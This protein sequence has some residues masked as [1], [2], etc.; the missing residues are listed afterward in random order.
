[1]QR[2]CKLCVKYT[3][4]KRTVRARSYY[5]SAFQPFFRMHT[6]WQQESAAGYIGGGGSVL[7]FQFSLPQMSPK[8]PARM[9]Q[10]G[11]TL[12]HPW[13]S[14]HPPTGASSCFMQRDWRKPGE[15]HPLNCGVSAPPRCAMPWLWALDIRPVL[16][17]STTL[18]L[19]CPTRLC[20][21][22][23]AMPQASSNPCPN[24]T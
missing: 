1:M 16:A 23:N 6:A 9:K 20:S 17:P 24:A 18:L 19:R 8:V 10:W 22:H 14:H 4:Q 13:I 12:S 5:T 7:V 2:R 21:F 3:M 11:Q 15:C